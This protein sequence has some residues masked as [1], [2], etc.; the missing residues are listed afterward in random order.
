MLNTKV[1]FCNFLMT[2]LTAAGLAAVSVQMFA[3]DGAKGGGYVEDWSTHHAVFT[4]PGPELDALKS[5]HYDQWLKVV[6]DPRFVMQQQKRG[7]TVLQPTLVPSQGFQNTF[8]PRNIFGAGRTFGNPGGIEGRTKTSVKLDKDWSMNGGSLPTASLTISVSSAPGAGTVSGTSTVTVDGQTFTGSTPVAA[9]QTG[10]F[11]GNPTTGQT[12]T[13]AGTE[14]VTASDSTAATA[15][16]TV[17]ASTCFPTNSGISVNGTT[18][19]T[20][21]GEGTGTYTVTGTGPTNAETI[22]IGGVTYTFETSLTGAPTNSVLIGSSIDNTAR[23]LS[24]AIAGGT[25]TCGNGT[26]CTNAT[27]AN[28]EVTSTNTGA[29]ASETMTAKC[30]NNAA[31]A[32]TGGTGITVNNVAVGTVGTTSTTARTIA[33]GTVA[34][35]NV[36]TTIA[37]NINTV[38]NGNAA[39]SAAFTSSLASNVVNISVDAW[40]TGG[41]ADTLAL[42]GTPTG[43]TLSGAT[44]AGGVDGTNTGTSFA[45]VN[46]TTTDAT[47]LAS[48]ITRG[49]GALG[50]TATSAGA[51]VTV[52]QT[53][54]GTG[55]NG[56]TSVATNATGFAWT[57]GTTAGGTDGTDS[58][59]GFKY[60]TVNTYDTQA[61]LATDLATAFAD[62]ATLS[63]VISATANTGATPPNVL[64]TAFQGG[65]AGNAY[66]A[67]DGGFSALTLGN[68]GDFAGGAGLL[69]NTFPAKYSFS[70]T[71]ESC[72]D[73]VVFPTGVGGTN[74]TLIAYNNIYATTCTGTVPTVAWAYNTGGTSIL[75]P[76]ISYDGTQVAY[77]QTS[78][79]VASLVILKPSATSGGTAS[80]P[81]TANLVSLGSYPA[82]TAPCYTTITL[83]GS[84]NDTNSSP[85]YNYNPVGGDD[86]WVGDNS[87]NLH[88]FTGVFLGTP[89]ETT[90]NWPVAVDSGATL[91]SPVWESISN[92]VF[93]GDSNGKL[94]YV[95]LASTPAVTSSAV[96]S[97]AGSLGIVDAPLIDEAPA[98]P[99]VYAFVGNSAASTALVEQFSTSFASGAAAAATSDVSSGSGSGTGSVLY[100]GTFDNIHY[101]IGGTGGFMWV[102]GGHTTFTE[103]ELVRV[104]MASFATAG[105][106]E[107][108]ITSGAATCS[109]VTEFLGAKANTTLGGAGITTNA[110]TAITVAS[111]TGIANGDY[112]QLGTEI[113]HVTAGGGT[114]ALTVA[115]GQEGTTAAASYPV[116]TA[117]QDI[118]DWAYLSVSATGADTGCT[119]ACL[120]NY[121]VTTTTSPTGSTT[122][123]AATGGTSGIVIDNEL[124][125]S[126]ESQIYYSTLSNQGCTGTVIT[127]S[128]TGSCAVQTSQSAP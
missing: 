74:A 95:N 12:V 64:L 96:L 67:T 19:T 57:A 4:N 16:V 2:G 31:I 25:G 39:L 84:P 9:K 38:I 109:P 23:N 60:W 98:T 56:A 123:I 40:G 42:S 46:N 24:V 1:S 36:N 35:T 59:N 127:G 69:A 52:T 5:S 121:S 32:N 37:T 115:R 3:Q 13:I 18:I 63:G 99:L 102:C 79:N 21:A 89:A 88:Q 51:V 49:D 111:G 117:V 104:S 14:V 66:T 53:T 83:S 81:A 58:T 7:S 55:G 120:Y 33:L 48:A 28:P 90:T 124:T 11:S 43:L 6:N 76:V 45:I 29:V 34:G 118:Q 15:S 71:T 91:T 22:S 44:F 100:A 62:N 50:I 125:G 113:M 73:Y 41:N 77:I 70:T 27:V 72:S 75:S 26:P 116:G 101:D 61:Q 8:G 20:T 86:L 107:D 93:V 106:Q 97:H 30:G 47:N 122:G 110:Q 65:T 85:Y 119:G 82:C 68:G 128:G 105:V 17:G 114:T 92:N 87:G 126:G 78:S 54:P 112:L 108:A 94:S 10:T 80:S 103:P